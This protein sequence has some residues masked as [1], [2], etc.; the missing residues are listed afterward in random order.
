MTNLIY[1]LRDPRND[2]YFYIGK[3]T[4]GE[5]RALSH[6]LKSHSTLV[7]DWVNTLF[8]KNIVPYVDI[9]EEVNNIEELSNREKYWINFYKDFNPE[10]LN[11]KLYK[12]I[13]RTRNKE[14]DKEFDILCES[15]NNLHIILKRERKLRGINQED[16]SKLSNMSRSTI[17][18]IESGDNINISSIKKYLDCI[19]KIKRKNK[20]Y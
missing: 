7:N 12:N 1:G 13:N 4:I 8:E 16:L 20:I 5:K 3:T 18:L 10:L 2:V 11:I 6:L 19:K 17:S 14:T 9:I 15:I